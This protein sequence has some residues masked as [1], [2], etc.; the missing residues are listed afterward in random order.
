M[1]K[2]EQ[3]P[4]AVPTYDADALET[5]AM[6]ATISTGEASAAS[7]ALDPRWTLDTLAQLRGGPSGV[8]SAGPAGGLELGS[9]LG[10]GG[11]GVVRSATQLSLGRD[12][13]VKTLREDHRHP[14]GVGKLLREA[15]IT[16]SL[17]HPNIVP[18]YDLGLDAAGA[19]M[20]VLKR[21]S[22]VAL[23]A[24][25]ADPELVRKRFG[26]G[27]VLEWH[28]RTLMQVCSAVHF[29]HRRGIVH[30]DIKPENIMVGEFGE[31]YVLDWGIAVALTDDGTRRFPLAA[32]AT[33]IA[34]TPLYMAPEMFGGDT[35]DERTDVYLLGATLYEIVSGTPPHK[36]DSL[37]EI[38]CSLA[39]PPPLPEGVPGELAAVWLRAMAHAPADRF[40]SA[41]ELRLAIQSFLDH[42]ASTRLAAGAS[43]SL[44]ELVRLVASA[45]SV[46][47]GVGV[48]VDV[49]RR[50]TIY[51]LFGECTFGFRQ[52]VEEW[53]ENDVARVGLR[54][55]TRHMLRYEIAQSDPRAARLLLARLEPPDADLAAEVRALEGR[56]QRSAERVKV[57]ERL[58]D[59]MD[60]NAGRRGR[61]ALLVALGLL[62]II[63]PLAVGRLYP[64]NPDYASMLPIPAAL[65]LVVVGAAFVVRRS[66]GRT[67]MN[68]AIVGA[69][70]LAFFAQLGVHLGSALAKVPPDESQRMIPFIWFLIAATMAIALIPRLALAAVA[71]LLAYLAMSQWF[72]YRYEVMATANAVLFVTVLATFVGRRRAPDAALG[73]APSTQQ[74]EK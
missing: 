73:S 68:R 7:A 19:P 12:V 32:D 30:R 9:V 21:I 22:G 15:L 34:G 48:G 28:L 6:A 64:A 29:A 24:L 38:M 74:I 71:Y 62:W 72:A 35:P 4:P 58:G 1:T 70:A 69:L 25:L 63:V 5:M 2:P 27:E 51:N 3:D 14:L 39:D 10:E 60:P 40:A 67:V 45:E 17:E 49:E 54:D 26:P 43:A 57:L 11:M 20:L 46:G 47:V 23:R 61:A 37:V 53:P 66:M 16:G 8:L 56:A 50:Q 65:L 41:E 42:R 31:V 52:A 33:D 36:G 13:A 55:A 59:E 18:V 44:A